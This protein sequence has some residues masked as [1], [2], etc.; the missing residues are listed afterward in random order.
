MT[1]VETDVLIV[2]SGPA[3]ASAG[4][5]L[6]TYGV[7]NIMV[8][9]YS[10]LADTP[11]AHITNQ[12]TMEVL[13]GDRSCQRG[14]GEVQPL[15]GDP[16]VQGLGECREVAQVPEFH[17]A[18]RDQDSRC[19]DLR[20]VTQPSLGSHHAETRGTTTRSDARCSSVS[21]PVALDGFPK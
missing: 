21:R 18:S 5:A 4:L 19:C 13:R 12:R 7:P 17:S 14:L 8:T 20:H 11:R 1:M 6:S 9:R 16:I 3:G 10:R 2:G 15:G